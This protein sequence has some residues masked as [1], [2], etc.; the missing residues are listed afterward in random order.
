MVRLNGPRVVSPPTSATPQLCAMTVQT[1]GI[2]LQPIGGHRRQGQGKGKGN[3]GGAH[4]GQVAD[5]HGQRTL[6]EQKRIARVCEMHTGHQRVGGNRQLLPGGNSQQGAVI[7]DP[8]GNA[9]AALRTRR[10]GEEIADQLK[11]AHAGRLQAP[12][13][14]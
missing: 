12:I 3:G 13:S 8:E 11:L 7:A 1:T 4:G 2:G 9:F 14:A 6:T 10:G 5:R